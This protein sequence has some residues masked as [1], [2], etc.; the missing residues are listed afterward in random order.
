MAS[1]RSLLRRWKALL[2]FFP[3]PY[4]TSIWELCSGKWSASKSKLGSSGISTRQL[5]FPQCPLPIAS[6]AAPLCPR[7]PPSGSPPPCHRCTT[8]HTAS[9]PTNQ[10]PH[11]PPLQPHL[12]SPTSP[13]APSQTHFP[14]TAQQTGPAPNHPVP[15][16]PPPLLLYSLFNPT[17]RR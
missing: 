15:T 6:H 12:S 1:R 9:L 16:C 5:G 4:S 3:A 11:A 14:A 7:L 8:T 2:Q 10:R 17:F 13:A